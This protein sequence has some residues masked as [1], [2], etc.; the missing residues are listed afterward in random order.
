MQNIPRTIDIFQN[1][2]H[3][4]RTHRQ[5]KSHIWWWRRRQHR[6][7]QRADM[8][9][10]RHSKE[11]KKKKV[12]KHPIIDAIKNAMP[13]QH[14]TSLTVHS[15][16]SITPSHYNNKICKRSFS[17][18][19]YKAWGVFVLLFSFP[20]KKKYRRYKKNWKP[21]VTCVKESSFVLFL[22]FFFAASF[23][24]FGCCFGEWRVTLLCFTSSEM[25]DR[26]KAEVRMLFNEL[27]KISQNELHRRMLEKLFWEGNPAT[28]QDSRF[29]NSQVSLL[30]KS[31]PFFYV[32]DD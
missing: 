7:V 28:A 9:K 6:V 12:E 21:Y 24:F 2:S 16:F 19:I 8:A 23:R 18:C 17:G 15:S 27:S 5:S 20:Q 26:E 3:P 1:F 25:R 31:Q 14:S 11:E 22:F 4:P 30:K 32:T 13:R 29:W 10:A